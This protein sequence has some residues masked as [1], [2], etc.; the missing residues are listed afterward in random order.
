MQFVATN[1]FDKLVFFTSQ[2]VILELMGRS[3]FVK[4]GELLKRPWECFVLLSYVDF[5]V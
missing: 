2:A 3:F 5:R 4:L 1:M